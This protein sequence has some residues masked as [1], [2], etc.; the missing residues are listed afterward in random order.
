MR[1]SL[2][3]RVAESPHSKKEAIRSY[4]SVADLASDTGYQAVCMRASQ[5]GIQTPLQDI[6]S[7]HR[8]TMARSLA[9]SMVTGD[10]PIPINNEHAPDA[11]RNITPYL[12]LTELLQSDLIRIGMK[13]D[14]DIIWAQR[15]CDEAQERGIR[16]AHQSHTLSLFETVSGSLDVLARVGRQN[17]GIIYEPANLDLCGED[18]GKETLKAFAPHLFNV[19]LQ[20]HIRRPGGSIS[21]DTWTRGTVPHDPIKLQDPG[22]IDF[23]LL[24]EG[25]ADIEY[26]GYVTVHQAFTQIMTPE[27]AARESYDY[28]TGICDFEEV[29]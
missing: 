20:N 13:S 22:G 28:L 11:L 10:F 7:V 3:V 6:A 12:D 24:F 15:A 8:E 9:V 18:Y 17:F 2:S 4:A 14:E 16:I 19:Y 29:I 25:L 23:P 27:D 5:A 1:L 26:S 21:L